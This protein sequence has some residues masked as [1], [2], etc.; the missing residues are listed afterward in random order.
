MGEYIEMFDDGPLLMEVS[1]SVCSA[2]LWSTRTSRRTLMSL[3]GSQN[4]SLYYKWI[5]DVFDYVFD[6]VFQPLRD[7]CYEKGASWT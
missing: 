4:P 1:A 6:T 2:K 3:L 7:I 5:D